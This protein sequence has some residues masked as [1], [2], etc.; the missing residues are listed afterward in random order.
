MTLLDLPQIPLTLTH[1][2]SDQNDLL[3]FTGYVD[4]YTVPLLQPEF[5]AAAQ[6]NHPKSGPL[7]VDLSCVRFMDRAGVEMVMRVGEEMEAQGSTLVIRLRPGSQ[8]ETLLRA[9][10]LSCLLAT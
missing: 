4:A 6:S 3:S 1:L 2:R 9:S 8:P 10:K 5:L 7:V